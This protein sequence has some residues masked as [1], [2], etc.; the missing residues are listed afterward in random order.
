MAKVPTKPQQ[1]LRQLRENYE[2]CRYCLSRQISVD[3]EI[4]NESQSLLQ[5]SNHGVAC[6]ICGGLM[7]KTESFVQKIKNSLCNDY[8]FDTFLIGATL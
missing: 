7:Y 4:N 8:C 5:P 2:L 1:I 3:T 6:H